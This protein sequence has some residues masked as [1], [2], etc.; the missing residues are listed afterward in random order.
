MAD[1]FGS[2]K[3]VRWRYVRVSWDTWD[4]VG[5]Y[6]NIVGG[7]SEESYFTGVKVGG[8]I[9]FDGEPP[10]SYDLVR[11]YYEFVDDEGESASVPV[12]TM[13]VDTAGLNYR[14]DGNGSGTS[15]L[16]SV[17]KVADDRQCGMPLTVSA[18]TNAVALAK[19]LLEGIGL[20]ISATPSTYTVA[21]DHVFK[22]TDTYLEVANWLMSAAGYGSVYPDAYGSVVMSPYVDASSRTPSFVF[23]DD[24]NSIMYP[25][26]DDE[27]D[28]GSTPNVCR[29][30]AE[31][32]FGG[33]W[34]VVSN[35]DEDSMASLP[36]RGYRERTIYE[37]ETQLEPVYDPDDDFEVAEGK[38][39]M[40]VE[41][42]VASATKKLVDNSSEIEYVTIRHGFYPVSQGDSVE[43]RYSD[44]A[45]RGVVTNVKRDHASESKCELK[46]RRYVQ[47]NI[48][49]EVESGVV[50]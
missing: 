19:E 11:T 30:Y 31:D 50:R 24:D 5:E 20:R 17:L 6:G 41:A 22:P 23:V 21:K 3:D 2:R 37:E 15:S 29:M 43:I 49:T 9:A 38:A 28:Y 32:E 16:Y 1:W 36:N 42:L 47:K 48:K 35:V 7:S 8:S 4:E 14:H 40:R 45:W 33:Y 34:C 26:V 25:E 18:G 13:L 10:S 12:C 46:I 44:K 39:L 27:N